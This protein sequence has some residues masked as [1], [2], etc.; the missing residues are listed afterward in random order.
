[1]TLTVSSLT[2]ALLLSVSTDTASSPYLVFRPDG[3]RTTM[4][5]LVETVL[6]HD[7]V[8]IGESHDDS[9]THLVEL[10]ILRK[11]R[12][13]LDSLDAD[14]TLVLAMEM[15]E[16]DV[17]TVVDEYLAGHIRERDFLAAARPWS[18]YQ[19]DYRPLIEYARDHQ[20]PVIASNAPARYVSYVG[21][22]GPE[23]LDSLSEQA[24]L[25]LPDLPYAPAS[26]P[27]ADKFRETMRRM[28]EE[29]RARRDTTEEDGAAVPPDS[30]AV[31]PTDTTVSVSERPQHDNRYML[32]A[33]N[34]RDAA[35]G[36]AVA[37]AFADDPSALVLHIN[38]SFH[39]D[40]GLGTPE[41]THSHKEDLDLLIVSVV[42]EGYPEFERESMG[43]LGD[44]IILTAQD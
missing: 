33:Q 18:N 12:E 22:H 2:A 1:M 31:A 24:N 20:L 30:S 44:F 4:S 32:E 29:M 19:S 7:V 43:N 26:G 5:E 17:Q 14:R 25:W 15:F 37:E 40:G 42:D 39:S 38:G 16:Q 9:V 23:A 11:T 8:F 41:H 34:L 6:A 28:M 35:M 36:Q 27:Y 10:E 3:S 21:R 13:R